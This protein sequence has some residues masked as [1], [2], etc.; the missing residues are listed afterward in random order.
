MVAVKFEKYVM[1]VNKSCG[2]IAVCLTVQQV[3]IVTTVL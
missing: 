1:R 2:Q 3:Q